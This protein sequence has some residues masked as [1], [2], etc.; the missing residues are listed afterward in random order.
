MRSCMCASVYFYIYPPLLYSLTLPLSLSL[1]FF[2]H[3][4]IHSVSR[5]WVCARTCN[6]RGRTRAQKLDFVSPSV[7]SVPEIRAT[8]GSDV[9]HSSPSSL[10]LSF[11]ISFSLSLT[12]YILAAF[13]AQFDSVFD[14]E[15]WACFIEK[16][17]KKRRKSWSTCRAH[18]TGSACRDFLCANA[19]ETEIEREEEER[20][21]D[22][23]MMG[24]FFT[25][26]CLLQKRFFRVLLSLLRARLI[27]GRGHLP[28]LFG[29]KLNR[30]E[31]ANW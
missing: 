17:K 19:T 26:R 5:T 8:G 12:L 27:V 22:E 11:S 30:P 23:G 31:R 24:T 4:Y 28:P 21:R 18:R 20:D 14:V 9:R 15:D 7:A 2:P 3:R 25:A 16:K 29:G 10:S 13:G 6:A 1:S